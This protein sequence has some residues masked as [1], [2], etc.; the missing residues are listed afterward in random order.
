MFKP[1]KNAVAI[2]LLSGALLVGCNGG[3]GSSSSSAPPPS[4]GGTGGGSGGGDTGGG[5]TTPPPPGLLQGRFVDIEGIDVTAEE[6]EPAVTGNGGTFN[7]VQNDDQVVFS[8]GDIDLPAVDAAPVITP[9]DMSEDG[10]SYDNT[11]INIMRLLETLDADPARPGIQISEEAKDAA[12]AVELSF[13]LEPTAFENSDALTNYLSTL[14]LTELASE[15]AATQTLHCALSQVGV[16]TATALVGSHIVRNVDDEL[17]AILVFARDGSFYMAQFIEE[18]EFDAFLGYETGTY[19]Q[20]GDAVRFNIEDDTNG[21]SGLLADDI[22]GDDA[23]ASDQPAPVVLRIT[24]STTTTTTFSTNDTPPEVFSAQRVDTSQGELAGTWRLDDQ[25]V[26]FVFDG[27]DLAGSYYL[28]EYGAA[29]ETKGIEAGTY[30]RSGNVIS[31][32]TIIDTNGDGGL[33]DI[34]G[35]FIIEIDGDRMTFTIEEPDGTETVSF[36]RID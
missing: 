22:G 29:D 25:D 17:D 20:L 3:G 33:S 14:G 23:C 9:L 24:A 30:T 19:S 21:T 11:V 12:M 13:E 15:A 28:I 35:G 27:D 5:T 36:T 1:S 32:T 34:E 26:V 7:Y 31:P 6:V 2:T 10:A 4:G 16:S 8:I 18:P